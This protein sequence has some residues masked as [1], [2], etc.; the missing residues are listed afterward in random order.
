MSDRLYTV[1]RWELHYDKRQKI[2]ETGKLT[3]MAFTEMALR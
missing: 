2:D 1:T 3:G